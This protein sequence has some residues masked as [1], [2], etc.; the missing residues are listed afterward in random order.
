MNIKFPEDFEKVHRQTKIIA[1]LGPASFEKAQIKSLIQAG[2]NVLRLNFSH[3]DYDILRRVIVDIRSLNKELGTT[4]GILGDLQGPKIRIGEMPQGGILF[5]P[6]DR[7]SLVTQP[8]VGSKD[9]IYINYSQLPQDI[10]PGDMLLLDDGKLKFKAIFSN[11]KDR[12]EMEVIAGG[13]LTSRKGV[14]LPDTEVALPSLTEKDRKDLDFIL[15]HKLDWVAL[16]FVRNAADVIV[17]REVIR[18]SGQDI[19]VMAKIE[20]PVAVADLENIISKSDAVMI[21]RGDLGVEFP[22][23]QLPLIQKH[24]VRLCMDLCKPVVVATQMMESMITNFM[25]TRAEANDVANAVLDGADALM[26]SGETSMGAHPSQ[27][28]EFMVRI[29]RAVEDQS[30]IYYRDHRLSQDSTNFISDQLC[31]LASRAALRVDAKAIV[32]FTKSGYTAFQVS[33]YRPKSG[34]IIFTPNRALLT[35]LSLVWGVR[36]LYYDKL[37]STDETIEDVGRILK[38][39]AWLQSGDTVVNTGVMPLRSM[40]RANFIKLTVID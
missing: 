21:A 37:T 20:K 32:G 35:R 3:A 12:I 27:V 31:Y 8:C 5:E 4:V 38:S 40:H 18:S 9:E 1:T 33:S 7:L 10:R 22:I 23:E 34:I 28:V 15:E 30:E 2:A 39:N 16:S 19:P 36:A 6:G 25:P 14:N 13:L 26:L 24:I 11:A 29:I 17:L